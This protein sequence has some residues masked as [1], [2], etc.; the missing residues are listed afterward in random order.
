MDGQQW[1]LTDRDRRA[2]FVRGIL[3]CTNATPRLY[4]KTCTYWIHGTNKGFQQVQMSV[5]PVVNVCDF[6]PP[7]VEN[8]IPYFI[9]ST[10]L[11][12]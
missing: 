10:C 5:F 8:P 1:G 12:I 11:N 6:P 3:A 4:R 7:P 9:P 2:T